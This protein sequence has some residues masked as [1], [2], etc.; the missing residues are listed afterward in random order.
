MATATPFYAALSA[1]SNANVPEVSVLDNLK[2]EEKS[3]RERKRVLS[4]AIKQEK[5]RVKNLNKRL[6]KIPVEEVLAHF[7]AKLQAAPTAN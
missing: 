1:L 4:K 3:S 6:N 5:R 7:A 2:S